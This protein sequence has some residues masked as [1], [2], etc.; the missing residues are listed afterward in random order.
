[1]LLVAR[2]GVECGVCKKSVMLRRVYGDRSE[3]KGRISIEVETEACCHA[4]PVQRALQG[5]TGHWDGLGT[6]PLRGTAGS[7]L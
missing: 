6:R 5:S 3:M 1:M 7:P 4:T 2:V